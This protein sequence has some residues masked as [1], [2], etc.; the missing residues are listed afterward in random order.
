MKKR[1]VSCISSELG[2]VFAHLRAEYSE[3]VAIQSARL[4][5]NSSYIYLVLVGKRQ[6]SFNL[7]KSLLE[8]Y[9]ITDEYKKVFINELIKPEQQARFEEICPGIKPEDLIYVL[10][11][12]RI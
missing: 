10:Y 7:F 12:E 3:T 8:H 5:F 4:G 6:F 1:S 11:G 2:K 9:T